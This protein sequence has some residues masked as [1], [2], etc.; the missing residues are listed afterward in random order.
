MPASQSTQRPR[1][2]VTDSA[3]TDYETVGEKL[4]QARLETLAGELRQDLMELA[5]DA[6][7]G[8]VS[9]E[10]FRR[11]THRAEM[12]AIEAVLEESQ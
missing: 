10:D 2:S 6:R 1:E 5:K 12:N 4:L 8:E 11:A 3:E 9:V 7:E